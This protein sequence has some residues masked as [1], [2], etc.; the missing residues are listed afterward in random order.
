MWGK[1]KKVGCYTLWSLLGFTNLHR[2]KF[3]PQSM[4]DGLLE[5]IGISGTLHM[6][7]I[8]VGMGHGK[9]LGQ[10]SSIKV[11]NRQPIAA[12]VDGE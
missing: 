5:I 4:D 7:M 2:Q 8:Q 1:E 12:Q 3:G 11:I 6:G 9:R 10:A